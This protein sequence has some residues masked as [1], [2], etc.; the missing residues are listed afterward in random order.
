MKKKEFKIAVLV[1]LVVVGLSAWGIYL[2]QGT[3]SR[4]HGGPGDL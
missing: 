2:G 3:G 1:L 4:R